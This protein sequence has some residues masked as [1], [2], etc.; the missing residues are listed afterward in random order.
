MKPKNLREALYQ[1]INAT[2]IRQ[3]DIAKGAKV[4]QATVSR[5]KN[6][7]PKSI[8][9]EVA[10]RIFNYLEQAE[11]RAAKKAAAGAQKPMN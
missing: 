2:T 6:N 3:V 4:G 1:K 9:L 10:E 8:S 7:K 11:A 5:I